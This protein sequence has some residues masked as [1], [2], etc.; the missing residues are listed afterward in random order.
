[1]GKS[2]TFKIILIASLAL[3]IAAIAFV[4]TQWVRHSHMRENSGMLFNRHAA[5]SA[6][7]SPSEKKVVS[8]WKSKREEM[9]T[10]MKAFR[11]SNRQLAKLLSEPELDEMQ[12][13]AAQTKM[14]E[15]RAN[16]ESLHFE[17]LLQSA[18]LMSLEERQKFFK[19]GFRVWGHN[20]PHR[21]KNDEDNNRD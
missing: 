20:G 8:L 17:V 6:L 7:E 13:R 1:M 2:K 10:E 15:H 19:R 11:Q 18:Q 9:R 5:M 12:I 14:T 16:A 3:N 21:K 4:T